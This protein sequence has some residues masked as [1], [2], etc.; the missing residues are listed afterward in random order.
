MNIATGTVLRVCSRRM[1]K[2]AR[3]T[4][5]TSGT[6][7]EDAVVLNT[8]GKTHFVLVFKAGSANRILQTTVTL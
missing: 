7:Q 5:G 3:I 1:D 6:D 4:G 8:G 2:E